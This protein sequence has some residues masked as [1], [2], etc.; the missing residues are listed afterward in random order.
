MATSPDMK[1]PSQVHD[2][3][4]GP[5]NK[6]HRQP[7]ETG[8][9]AKGRT[10]DSQGLATRV[11]Y[12]TMNPKIKR[13]PGVA[14]NRAQAVL[15]LL[16]LICFALNI[17]YYSNNH[18]RCTMVDAMFDPL[19]AKERGFSCDNQGLQVQQHFSG[20][21]FG[22]LAYWY[23]LGILGGWGTYDAVNWTAFCGNLVGNMT[24]HA[25]AARAAGARTIEPFTVQYDRMG[26]GSN[27]C[28]Y[29]NGGEQFDNVFFVFELA[30]G[31]YNG[32]S[33]SYMNSN[34]CYDESGVE[35]ARENITAWKL[36]SGSWEGDNYCPDIILWDGAYAAKSP[37][38]EGAE[39]VCSLLGQDLGIVDKV[40]S[41]C[42]K[43]VCAHWCTVLSSALA[44]TAALDFVF[45]VVIITVHNYCRGMR[46]STLVTSVENAGFEEDDILEGF[47]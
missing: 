11:W 32:C 24:A 15:L 18:Q 45:L 23:G 13:L 26:G 10:G 36:Y 6:R 40:L 14:Q 35:V 28:E 21:T 27:Q 44:V 34:T 37:F 47:V 2:K 39:E 46:G 31:G 1:V 17:A 43:T 33:S 29:T 42:F 19:T 25:A 5:Y 41:H 7:T 16:S 12:M 3:I 8:K 30:P 20:H 22:K 4:S 38:S 9:L